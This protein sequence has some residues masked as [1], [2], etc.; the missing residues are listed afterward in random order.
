ME[1]ELVSI[2]A[3]VAARSRRRRSIEERLSRLAVVL[4]LG[5]ERVDA[6]VRFVDGFIFDRLA[7]R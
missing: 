2:L 1:V 5:M 7:A 3:L 6:T 4:A